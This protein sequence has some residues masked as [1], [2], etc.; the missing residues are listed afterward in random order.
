MFEQ[1]KLHFSCA[2]AHVDQILSIH[3]WISGHSWKQKLFLIELIILRLSFQQVPVF[4]SLTGLLTSAFYMLSTH[5]D[6]LKGHAL[7]GPTGD[8]LKGQAIYGVRK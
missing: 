6:S 1:H 2:A 8:V 7:Y 4:I 3:S 5:V